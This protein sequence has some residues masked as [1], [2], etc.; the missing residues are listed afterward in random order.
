[1]RR[2]PFANGL[3]SKRNGTGPY[4]LVDGT[5]GECILEFMAKPA[6]QRI[7]DRE[8]LTQLIADVRADRANFDAILVYAYDSR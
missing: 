5:P 2:L 7:D 3:H 6:I 8:A 4:L 1:M